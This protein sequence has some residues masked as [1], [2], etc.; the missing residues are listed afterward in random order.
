MIAKGAKICIKDNQGMS[1]LHYAV[2]LNKYENVKALV[3]AGC[4]IDVMN[5]K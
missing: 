1:A 2:M 4:D 5:K 3:E